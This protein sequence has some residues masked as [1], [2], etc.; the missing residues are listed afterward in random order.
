M[1]CSKVSS[2]A[3]EGRQKGCGVLEYFYY[4]LLLHS[5]LCV[6]RDDKMV[7]RL[8]HYSETLPTSQMHDL[9]VTSLSFIPW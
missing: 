5:D 1:R 7:E 8:V 3:K 2:L 4:L 9:V 6:S